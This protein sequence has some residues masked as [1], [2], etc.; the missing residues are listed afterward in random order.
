M[1]EQDATSS[2]VDNR[3]ATSLANDSAGLPASDERCDCGHSHDASH[4]PDGTCLALD[5]GCVGDG[6]NVCQAFAGSLPSL[7]CQRVTPHEGLHMHV[8][9]GGVHLWGRE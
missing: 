1:T 2:A 9:D 8:T 3:P 7:R 6:A 5:C 4:E